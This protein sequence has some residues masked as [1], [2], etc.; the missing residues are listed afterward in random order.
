MRKMSFS[1]GDRVMIQGKLRMENAIVCRSID[2]TDEKMK[3]RVIME[4]GSVAEKLVGKL[5]KR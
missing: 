5:N 3:I 2:T 1:C 4:D